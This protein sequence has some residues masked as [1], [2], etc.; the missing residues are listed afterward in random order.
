MSE[1]PIET[2][3]RFLPRAE[4]VSSARRFVV[5]ALID[6]GQEATD[7]AALLIS[8]VVS[9]VV[10]HVGPDRPDKEMIVS[11]TRRANLVRVEVT[12][13]DRGMPIIGHGH[14]NALSGRGLILLDA[15]ASAWGV[16]PID[17]GKVVWFEVKR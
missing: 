6:W 10:T 17:S 2:T 14:A 8:E 1:I 9:N 15:L 16:V 5:S 13:S 7:T 11:L 12:D 3:R 4:S